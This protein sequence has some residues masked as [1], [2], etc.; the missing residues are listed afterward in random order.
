MALTTIYADIS[1]NQI[2][3]KLMDYILI[4]SKEAG[5]IFY[6]KLFSIAPELRSY[7]KETSTH[8]HKTNIAHHLCSA[9]T[10]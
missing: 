4:N 7:L 10:K 3:G 6:E 2:S 9:Q 8:N 5:T 1:P